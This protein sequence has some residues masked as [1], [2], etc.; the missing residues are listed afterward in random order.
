MYG[1]FFVCFLRGN[2]CQESF[3]GLEIHSFIHGTQE[4]FSPFILFQSMYTKWN[5][6]TCFYY[7]GPCIQNDSMA[8][9]TQDI[10][11]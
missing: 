5:V 2:G 4:V 3:G 8:L 10:V 1:C 6:W 11:P 9:T 7:F